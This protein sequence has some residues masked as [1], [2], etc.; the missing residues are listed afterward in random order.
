MNESL[1]NKAYR[2]ETWLEDH[3]LDENG[4]VYTAL[5]KQTCR[6]P[7]ETL[8]HDAG[9]IADPNEPNNDFSVEG[10][11]RSDVARY[12]NCGMTTGAYLQALLFRFRVEKDPRVLERARR[13]FNALKHIF[14]MGKQLE[15][16]FFP[17]IY[18]G[19]FSR[20]TSTDQVLYAV[21]A[22]DHFHIF[23]SPE[24]KNKIDRM[25][26]QMIG[27]WVK[28]NYK[29][30]YFYRKDMQWP[31]LRFPPLLL[32]AYKHSGDKMFMD[33]Y[34]RLLSEGYTREPEIKLLSMKKNEEYEP[35]EYEKKNNAW[36]LVYI[37]DYFTM[38][39]M[40]TGYLLDNDPENLFYPDWK[41]SMISMWEDA[42]LTLAP[43]GKDYCAVYVDMLTGKVRRTAGRNEPEPEWMHGSET[44]WSTMIVRAAVTVAKYYPDNSEIKN[45]VTNVLSSL[46]IKDLTY[47]DESERLPLKFG[48]KTRFLSGDSIS[49]WLWAYWQAKYQKLIQ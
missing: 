28:R 15:E 27:F 5:D 30:T 39:V 43:N 24:E 11:S 31:L 21:M 20:Q 41:E 22:M 6:P 3:F 46:D 45:A 9:P 36:L 32:L 44:G 14:N 12:E 47:Y 19:R 26:A 2:I 29:Y 37:N 1:K 7:E 8:F 48:F 34:K 16:G 17:K 4:V 40:D 35:T 42:K 38:H 33:E 13:C 18:G 49:N 23:A 25:I 10:C